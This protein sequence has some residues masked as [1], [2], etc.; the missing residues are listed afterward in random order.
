M[1]KPILGKQTF[2]TENTEPLTSF[3]RFEKEIYQERADEKPRYTGRFLVILKDVLSFQ[4]A[5]DIFRS[6][7]GLRVAHSKDFQFIPPNE[8]QLEDADVLIYDDLGVALV[9]G[10]EDQ[11]RKL[12]SNTEG[13]IVTPERIVY[14]PNDIPAKIEIPSTWGLEVTG[15][16]DSSY[17]GKGIKVAVLDTGFD[18][19]HPD[20]SGRSITC[21]SFVPN[22]AVQDLHGHG[23]HCIGTACGN[24]DLN[25]LR[26][27]VAKDSLI[28]AGKVL[29]NQGSGAQSWILSG[30]T[31]AANNGC[32]V[33]SMSLGSRV[34]PDQEFDPAYERAAQ[35][36]ITKGC[37]V[38]AAA[39][40]ESRRS[41]NE[42]NPVGS[43]ANCPSV[44]A[45]AALDS[46]L[47]VADF[48]NRS[49]NADGKVDIA[50]PGVLI[51]SSW[52]APMRYRTISGTSM[53]APHVAGIL[54]LL[55]EKY[56]ESSPEEIWQ[57]LENLARTL[58][59][60]SV[61]IGAGLSI[62]P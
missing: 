23:T 41:G 53:A 8:D 60:E 9:S 51:Y 56:P 30:M 17:T 11:I 14:V 46:D 12:A 54:A 22:E 1:K 55:W 38:V 5:N 58:P 24:T 4:M 19:N 37:V 26:Y 42:F 43:P 31:W 45:V 39:G 50:A 21:N 34:A 16:L 49:I 10:E 47:E 6:N 61:D 35:Y 57:E 48:S 13:L 3:Q 32:K 29:N 36:A 52:P 7:L 33:I 44:M 59:L 27:G 40:N 28:Y 18:F 25:M 20:F 62:A 2:L 15:V